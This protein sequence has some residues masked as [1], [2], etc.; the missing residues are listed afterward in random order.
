MAA[1]D[2]ARLGPGYSTWEVALAPT[3]VAVTR[4]GAVGLSREEYGIQ[5]TSR[6]KWAEI[7]AT[8][9]GMITRL[10]DQFGR[11][12]SEVQGRGLWDSTKW[13]SDPSDALVRE[14]LVRRRRGP[15]PNKGLVVAD[16]T[17]TVDLL[18]TVFELCGFPNTFPY[19]G[20]SL[21][22]IIQLQHERTALAGK[23]TSCRD[24]D[25]TYVHRLYE[26]DELYDRRADPGERHNLAGR[27]ARVRRRRGPVP[28]RDA[29]FRWLFASADLLPWR[30]QRQDHLLVDHGPSRSC[31]SSYNETTST[32]PAA[33]RQLLRRRAEAVTHRKA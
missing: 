14:P 12:A 33:P 24:H 15:V 28:Y 4:R 30:R 32:L 7:A 26:P 3:T 5:N 8:Y 21:M 10:D 22:P 29:V 27:P 17:E 16:M 1:A 9:Y 11:I 13:P 6:E 31:C 2:L 18:P 19:N 20:K 25:F 23:A